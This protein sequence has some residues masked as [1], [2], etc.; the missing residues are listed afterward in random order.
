M[1]E[2]QARSSGGEESPR[3]PA[4]LGQNRDFTQLFSAQVISLVGSGVTSVALAA[5]AYQ[6]TGRDA[7]AVVGIALMLR[8][9]A[10]LL[11][12][13]PAG[14]LADRVN[15]KWVLVAS[16]LIRVGLLGLFPFLRAVWQIYALI[17]AINAVTA[18]FTPTFEASIP[19][20]VGERL[21]TRALSLSRVAT[22]LE[23]A[24]GP[25]LAGVL[26]AWVGVR[27]AFWFDGLTYLASAALVLLSRVPR[28][29]GST[30]FRWS[31]LV[32]EV[33]HGTRVLLRE[34][35]LRRALVLHMA[36][37]SAGAVAIVTTIVYVRDVLG[38]GDVAFA[39]AMAA[40]GAGSSA[41]ALLLA[42]GAEEAQAATGRALLRHLRYHRWAER[43]LVAGGGVLALALLPGVLRPGFA[44][45]LALWALN[46]AGQAMIAVPSVGLLAEHTEPGE[47]GRAYAAHFAWT[48]LFWLAT[49]PA[50]GFLARAA[51]TPLTFTVAGGLCVV[52]TGL[53][54]LMGTAHR[55]HPVAE[56]E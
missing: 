5:F 25:L 15:R 31:D 55:P 23:A 26:I 19:E 4:G 17:F 1:G 2:A 22:D 37:A 3:A 44:I 46:G 18:F 34:P 14:V 28:A 52:L 39:V 56:T 42:K 30:A 47:W 41:A 29:E 54:S 21:Y 8:I 43:S 48:H 50:A 36:E 40:L 20:V 45:L 12:S 53:A 32:R 10:F 38:R 51:G 24:L 7:T 35:A 33:T 16:D 27:W 49:Y 9:L 13:Q 11:F 6:L